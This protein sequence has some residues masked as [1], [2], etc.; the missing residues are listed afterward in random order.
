MALGQLSVCCKVYDRLSVPARFEAEQA[1]R[2][3]ATNSVSVG[4]LSGDEV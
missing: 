2:A 3:L 1:V 4:F